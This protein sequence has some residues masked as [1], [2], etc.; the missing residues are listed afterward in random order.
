MAE[1]KLNKVLY[2]QITDLKLC[3]KKEPPMRFILEQSP[4]NDDDEDDDCKPSTAST[5]DKEYSV[6]GRIFPI[7]EIFKEASYK[8]EMK[9]SKTYPVTPPDV[10]FLTPIYHPNVAKD[11][12][13]HFSKMT[14]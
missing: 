10:R 14:P 11:G 13:I 5:T 8:I 1:S 3:N 9:L 12:I 6:I 2:T 4:F 7:S